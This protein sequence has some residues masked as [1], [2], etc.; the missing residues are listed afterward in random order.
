MIRY[1][2]AYAQGGKFS[3][4]HLNL[5]KFLTKSAPTFI[6]VR[7]L[8]LLANFATKLLGGTDSVTYVSLLPSAQFA[9]PTYDS[10][11][12]FFV[13]RNKDY[14]NE[15]TLFFKNIAQQPFVFIDG[16]AN[17]G[18]WSAILSSHEFH[19]HPCLAI[20]ASEQTFQG[21]LV[22][23]KANEERF[24]C[25]KRAIWSE[26][27]ETVSFA[28]GGR[29][30][31][32]HIVD[33]HIEQMSV[34]A[35]LAFTPKDMIDQVETVSLD[36]L[37]HEHF[38]N[39]ESFVVKL[40]IEGAEVNAFEGAKELIEKDSIFIYEDF[41]GDRSSEVTSYLLDQ[42]FQILFPRADGKLEP[43]TRL[44]EVENIKRNKRNGYNFVA[45]KSQGPLSRRILSLI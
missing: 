39:H 14:E 17:Y 33:G 43:I 18:Y 9:F 35:K 21:L 5:M 6:G 31:G 28:E 29:H 23:A 2:N 34:N 37:I 4:F 32:R 8:G 13:H 41:G 10:Y 30:A 20:E 11:W 19:S 38:P 24:Q 16:G 42:E 26:S 15:L 45:L 27:G 1:Q 25:M 36:D 44:D 7:G 12:S 40:D 22:T 3:D